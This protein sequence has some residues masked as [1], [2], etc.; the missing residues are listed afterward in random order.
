MRTRWLLLAGALASVSCCEKQLPQQVVSR[1]ITTLQQATDLLG[2]PQERR[3]WRDDD[4]QYFHSQTTAALAT[5]AK[6]EII[7]IHHWKFETTF[8][9][10]CAEVVAVVD[11]SGRVLALNTARPVQ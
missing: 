3:R 7:E 2:P 1:Q 10:P 8:G 9:R 11:E 6:T 4:G 5:K